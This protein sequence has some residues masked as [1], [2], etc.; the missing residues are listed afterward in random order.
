MDKVHNLKFISSDKG[1]GLPGNTIEREFKSSDVLITTETWGQMDNF[2]SESGVVIAKP[3][4]KWITKWVKGNNYISTKILDE[5][6]GVV[7]FYFDV[8]SP[9]AVSKGVFSFY[10]WYIDVWYPTGSNPV[11]LDE[12]E[13][14]AAL[15]EGYL[16]K[17]DF[18]VAIT[19]GKYIVENI[20]RVSQ[21]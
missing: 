16:S 11:I 13:C 3:G 14:K 19:T 7:A 15:N 10:D 18:D 6:G 9:I 8:C 17:N 1:L 4:Y 5:K 21:F 20:D 2:W 12:E